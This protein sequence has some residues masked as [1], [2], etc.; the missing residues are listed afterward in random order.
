[1][2]RVV[3]DVMLKPEILDP[4]G[5]AV[6][7][8]AGPAG[9]DRR[10]L[11]P[12]GQAVRD[13]GRRRARRGPAR[14]GSTS[15]PG[16]LLGNPVI[17]DY[18]IYEEVARTS[19][20][21][22][23]P[24]DRIGVVTFPGSL[25][26]VRRAA[27]GPRSPGARGGRRSG[28]ATPTCAASTRSSLPGGLLL[29][30]LPAL[31]RD[32]PVRPGRWARSS[33]R[34]RDGLPVLGHLQRLPDP[35]RVAPAAR[36]ADPQRRPALRLPRPGAARSRTPR[37]PGRRDYDAGERIVVPLKNGEGRF[38]ADEAHARRA[39]GRGPGRRPLRR[40]QPERLP[41]RHRRHLQRGGQ[42]RRPDAAPRARRRGA[43]RPRHRRAGLLHLGPVHL[44]AGWPPPWRWPPA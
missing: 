21:S 11:R 7:G 19:R 14:S 13:R 35:V 37:P 38:Q 4:Q 18:E 8:R 43:D 36:R 44:A 24:G 1:M 10:H 40:R 9:P 28:M 3:V 6:H 15:S 30:R 34:R 41:A 33:T 12:P 22:E 17:E 42:R 2:A 23:S 26:D 16:P 5:R 25:D 27:R 39:R 31:R 29:R 20:R 32:R